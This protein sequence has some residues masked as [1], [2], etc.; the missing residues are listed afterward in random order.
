MPFP[1]F[2]LNKN[3]ETGVQAVKQLMSHRRPER[4]EKTPGGGGASSWMCVFFGGQ[5]PLRSRPRG[6]P[7]PTHNSKLRI[8]SYDPRKMKP[9]RLMADIRGTRPANNLQ[10][11]KDKQRLSPTWES[12]IRTLA[13]E[14][15]EICNVFLGSPPSHGGSSRHFQTGSTQS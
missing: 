11:P 3:S 2:F 10:E 4:K 7:E 6:V 13:G 14:C 1:P 12:S 9:P 5:K 15:Q 8:L